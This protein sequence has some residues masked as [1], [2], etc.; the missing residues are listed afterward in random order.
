MSTILT[1]L[2][3][4]FFFT[5]N[6]QDV[7]ALP[8]THLCHPEQRVALLE[9]KKE[10]EISESSCQ[11]YI[12]E[13]GIVSPYPK[14]ESWKNNTDCCYWDG[15]TCDA[16]TGKVIELNLTSS[17]LNGRFHSNT[18][19]NLGFLIVLDLSFNELY[20]QI[21]PSVAKLSHLTS[22][23]ISNN[24]FSGQ[25]P[26]SIGNLSRLA[27]LDISG[28]NFVGEIPSTFGRLN[29]LTYLRVG[30][31]KLSGNFPIA[32]LN[33]TNLS[34]LSLYYNQFT[35]TLPPNITSLPD[36]EYLYADNN[37]F[38]GTLHYSLSTIPSVTNNQLDGPLLLPSKLLGLS[39]G[40]NRFRGP[41]P[42]SIS[43]LVNLQVLDM[44]HWNTQGPVD[45]N[46]FS[47]LKSL[48]TLDL[49]YLNTTTKIDLTAISSFSKSLDTLD[50]S[51]NHVL[52]TNKSSVS[53]PPSKVI[54]QLLLQGCGITEFP[55]LLRTQQNMAFLKISNN[56]I[57]GQVPSWLWTLP[58]L[59]YVDLSNNNFIGMERS[60]KHGVSSNIVT[61]DISNNE[62]KVSEDQGNL[63]YPLPCS[64]SR[65]N[66]TGHIPSL[67]CE[68][69]S[70]IILDLSVNDFNGSIPHCLQNLKKSLSYLNLRHNNL[71]GRLPGNVIESLKSIDVG[72]N[73]L[74]GKL[75]RSL[76]N[77]SS[78]EVL[79]VESNR[80]NN[81]FPLWLSSLQ[82]LQILILRSN[83]FNGPIYQASFSK[84]Q[85]VDISYNQFS[86][87]L[88]SDYF[89][90]WSAMSSLG[91]NKDQSA[92]KY[93]GDKS[94]GYYQDS[95]VLKNKGREIEIVRILKV[96]TALDF[97]QN[98]FEGEIP[99]SV[100][101]L[102]ELRSLSMS[103]NAFTGHI[104]SSMGNLTSLESLDVSQNKLSGEIPQ[105]LGTL[106]FLSYM[107]FSN[108][109]LAGLVPG[110]TQFRTQS[111]SSFANNS[112][113]FGPALDEACSDIRN[114]IKHQRLRKK[115][116][117]K[118]KR[119]LVGL[120]LQ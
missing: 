105:E 50:L 97:S 93:M 10:L 63:E 67:V 15:I 51:G 20:G 34:V 53:D 80:I 28:N 79:N 35:G 45:F 47:H 24:K 52:A 17:C 26:Y 94:S 13:N 7:F 111:C 62:I 99:E 95:I 16:K 73:Q 41:I 74:V 6:F 75:P 46:I 102:K 37:D 22:F 32:I 70:L 81:V 117:K 119:C 83:E 92:E 115:K 2:S 49:S 118:K 8:S 21:L 69:R 82:N 1:T 110:G 48:I 27:A 64:T 71:S 11:G 61:L 59:W 56:K 3:F 114:S 77:F 33:L 104:P 58:K 78:L 60:I 65:N 25:I 55:E 36:L 84:L 23:D 89:V 96:L 40:S 98:R 90:G 120:Q 68:L 57:K 14:T 44:S 5:F 91:T 39:L 30:S 12:N 9:I 42:I 31:N 113:L 106:S 112:G 107:N 100:G 101:L 72:Y 29:Q 76:M 4:L 116:K 108:N 103:N 109:Q 19:Q 38:V 54:R 88:P 87:T 43:K 86:G 66:F 85:I 18:L